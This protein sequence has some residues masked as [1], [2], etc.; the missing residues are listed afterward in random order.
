MSSAPL[1]VRPGGRLLVVKTSSLGDVIHATPCLRAIRRSFPEAH[2]A[3]AV[4]RRFVDVVAHNP[5]VDT[6]VQTRPSLRGP[7]RLPW[8]AIL[9]L[10]REARPDAALDL[11]GTR[12]S[13]ALVYASRARWQGGRGG[14]RPGWQL[15]CR[16][17]P[18]R[19]AVR[20]CAEIATAAGIE[21]TDLAPVVFLST[22]DDEALLA[23]LRERRLPASGF[24]L[25]NPFSRWSS[26][27]WPLERYAQLIVAVRAQQQVPVVISGDSDEVR[28]AEQLL[29]L[30]PAGAATSLV[31][32]LPLGQALCLYR[33]AL[34]MVTGD[35]GPMH[36]A[37]A[38][39]T[40]VIALFGPTL[41]ERTGPWGEGHVVI[42][43]RRPATHHAYQRDR[44]GIHIRAIA[45]EP[46]AAAVTSAVA[47]L[48]HSGEGLRRAALVS[49]AGARRRLA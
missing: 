9:R 10:L 2:L 36:A 12:G 15:V 29:S 44:E 27:A 24:V 1:T 19:H 11:Q 20:V 41:P 40:P 49:G 4:D 32:A 3:L 14:T 42:Q 8:G 31:G 38:L 43:E 13:A 48:R 45:V 6:V 18:D 46:V 26:K 28:G 33:R 39:G 7:L 25:V 23:T 37:A 35:S 34:L 47:S 21:V 16:P 30:L 17:D 5:D 22:G